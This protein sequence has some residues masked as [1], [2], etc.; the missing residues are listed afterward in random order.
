[1]RRIS[2]ARCALWC[3]LACVLISGCDPIEPP[4]QFQEDACR[5]ALAM[6]ETRADTLGVMK[7]WRGNYVGGFDGAVCAAMIGR[8]IARRDSAHV[9][10]GLAFKP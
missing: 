5:G 2:R 10:S 8:E 1:M 3:G 4:R 6:A 9:P 7:Q